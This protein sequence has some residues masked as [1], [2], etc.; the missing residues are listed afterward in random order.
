MA[1]G[2]MA[3]TSAMMWPMAGLAFQAGC[4]PSMPIP[5]P[6]VTANPNSAVVKEEFPFVTSYFLPN[7]PQVTRGADK[8]FRAVALDSEQ[9]YV[10]LKTE[11]H[12]DLVTVFNADGSL[13]TLNTSDLT[14]GDH[15]HQGQQGPMLEGSRGPSFEGTSS[16]AEGKSAQAE[17][18][19]IR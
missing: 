18:Y 14:L 11:V 13:T 3:A 4:F 15:P 7:G 2:M 9:K 1:S 8:E 19:L 6:L 17:G 16:Q 5:E 12:G 10:A